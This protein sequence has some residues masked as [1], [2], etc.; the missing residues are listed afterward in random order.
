VTGPAIQ[1]A[2]VGVEV[3]LPLRRAV[4]RPGLPEAECRYPEDLDPATLHL[5]AV[6]TGEGPGEVV[7]CSTWF[8]DP[9]QGRPAWRLRGM[10]TAPQVRGT[11]VGGLLLAYGLDMVAAEGAGE[12]WCNA[13]TKAVGFYRRYGF[14]TVGAEFL[15]AHGIPH[16]AMWRALD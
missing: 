10:A 15:A 4:L 13:R 3:L 5:A 16:F 12:V 14:V 2:R 1:L 8:A 7:A 6:E 9:W 11:G